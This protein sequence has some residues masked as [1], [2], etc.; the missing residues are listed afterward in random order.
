MV[1]SHGGIP[2]SAPIFTLSTGSNVEQRYL[3]L[4]D[5]EGL[6]AVAKR[7]EFDLAGWFGSN[8]ERHIALV[9]EG[10]VDGDVVG[11]VLPTLVGTGT[12]YAQSSVE[13]AA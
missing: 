4:S 10:D 2:L 9:L 11:F 13:Y 1:A 6:C 5:V 12:D 8:V 7:Y 3:S